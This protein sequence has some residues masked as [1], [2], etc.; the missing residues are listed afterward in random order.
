MLR[1]D[2]DKDGVLSLAEFMLWFHTEVAV[3]LPIKRNGTGTQAAPLY[4][5]FLYYMLIDSGA[6]VRRKATG[7]QLGHFLRMMQDW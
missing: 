6:G 1:A 3:A 4:S 7:L 2:Q 5:R